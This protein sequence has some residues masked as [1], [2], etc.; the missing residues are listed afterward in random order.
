[1]NKWKL[2]MVAVLGAA[3]SA[4]L[5]LPAQDIAPPKASLPA[6]N[7]TRRATSGP[8]KLPHIEVDQAKKQ[9][10]IDAAVSLQ[11]GGL[12]FLLCTEGSKD[13]ESLLTTKAQP[14]AVH[15]ALLALG[16]T[17][18]KPAQWSTPP[19]REPVFL[20]PRGALL[21]IAIRYEDHGKTV[22]IPATDWLLVS[23]TKKTAPPMKFVFVGSDILDDGSY[24]ADAEG[25]TISVANFASSVI[26]VP[27]QSTD[28]NAAL[29]YA[30]N[31]DAVPAKGTAVKVVITAAQGAETAPVARVMLAVDA[32][33]RIELDGE[34]IAPEKIGAEIE[35]FLAQH[36]Q[37]AAEVKIDP[38]ALVYDR[39]RLNSILQ[40]AGMTDVAFHTI[41]IETEILPRTKGEVAQAIAWWK[42]QFHDAGN[43]LLDPMKSAGV[44]LKEIER[45]QKE[46]Q[47][48]SKLWSEYADQIKA[49][50]E[51]YKK[52]TPPEKEGND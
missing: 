17:P 40:E 52:K 9:V 23:S 25:R 4:G 34:P 16:L 5:D 8:L 32:M 12:E 28:K 20:P 41:G 2:V 43:G 24:W 21:D 6:T 11:Q 13:Y 27:F 15:A 42:D 45:R 31:G 33:G 49:L 10:V 26:D 14:S 18:G 47:D 36:A 44:A 22:D 30:A 7:L 35:K 48:M 39:E 37:G 29:E 19:G 50:V 38:Q 1:M 46:T 51:E 3:W